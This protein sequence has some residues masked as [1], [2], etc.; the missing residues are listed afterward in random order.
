MLSLENVSAGY[1]G[2][3]VLHDIAVSVAAGQ[4]VGLIGPNGSGKTTLLRSSAACCL[5]GKEKSGSGDAGCRRWADATSPGAW[6]ISC[7]IGR[8]G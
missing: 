7:K 8:W 4:F 6:R 1:A 3:L 2:Q 5:P